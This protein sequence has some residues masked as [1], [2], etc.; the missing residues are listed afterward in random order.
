MT[1]LPANEIALHIVI[2]VTNSWLEYSTVIADIIPAIQVVD[3]GRPGSSND[4][5]T[6]PAGNEVV[7]VPGV[8]TE[9]VRVR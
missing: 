5:A 6:V 8:P 4:N 1:I 2:P 7:I 9:S 3:K